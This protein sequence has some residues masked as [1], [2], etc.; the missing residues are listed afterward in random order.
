MGKRGLIFEEVVVRIS[1]KF[2][3]E[4]HLDTD[5]GN[6][7]AVKNG[8][9]VEVITDVCGLCPEQ[10]CPIR[11]D[12]THAPVRPYCDFAQTRYRVR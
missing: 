6:A 8:D 11:E 9:L 3:T 4:M 12:A 5:E 1:D 7:A 10:Q 2:K